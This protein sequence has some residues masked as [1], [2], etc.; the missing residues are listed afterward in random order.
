MDSRRKKDGRNMEDGR[1]RLGMGILRCTGARI[2]PGDRRAPR[3]GAGCRSA[4]R[5]L[6]W[7]AGGGLLILYNGAF[8][9]HPGAD[10]MVVVDDRIAAIE[11]GGASPG[12]SADAE[13]VDL[14]GGAVFPGF[15]DAHVHVFEAGLAELGW[16]LDLAG[17]SREESVAALA[18]AVSVRGAGAWVLG[19]GWD[20][21]SWADKRPLGRKDLDRISSSSP[22]GA[23]RVDGHLLVLNS[24]ALGAAREILSDKRYRGLVDG[25]RGEVR[26]EAAWR[27]LESLEPDS[28]TLAD[29]FSAAARLF[30][31]H[32][33]TS[34]H[35]MMPRARAP[36]VLGA[37]GRERLRV[38]VFHRVDAAEKIADIR[39][40]ERFDG[41]WIRFGG[42]KAFADGSLGAGTAAVSEPY[43]DGGTGTLIHSGEEI[44][45]IVRA[46][47]AR[48]WR[49]AIHAIGDRAIGQVLEAHA[50][51]GSSPGLR[52]RI[53]HFELP[54]AEQIERAVDLGLCLSMQ[55][56]FTGNWSGPE[57]MY[58][59][60]LG[61]R[62]DEKS[63][64]LRRVID[65]GA[66]VA[67]GSDGMPV[68]PIYGIHWAVNA[69]YA[70]QRIGAKE[71][72]DAYT[73]GG[74][75]F[76]FEEN[77]KGRLEVGALADFV[78]LDEDPQIAPERI[79]QRRVLATYV[80]G[81]LVYEA[82]EA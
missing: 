60:K 31:R 54:A 69:S 19:G 79:E 3:R 62:R 32:G 8:Y 16:R 64:P 71:A 36:V 29:A 51:V 15:V 65:A 46:C 5:D 41:A 37:G 9:G 67:F 34:V 77:D 78:V 22:V 14:R 49:S 55:P 74:A 44:R 24:A 35:G 30:H 82:E 6:E 25:G 7:P 81:S 38:T 53:E 45:S 4:M 58:E 33:V 23:V 50:A 11:S 27:V 70:D 20:E 75:H 59:R 18:D 12:E 80:G 2:E 48:G 66:A 17:K 13:W 43:V 72:I 42:V 76:A 28:T 21:S 1:E 40:E 39:D 26:E 63:N 57:S 47:E 56:N 52:H 73:K 61:R 10:C 68:S